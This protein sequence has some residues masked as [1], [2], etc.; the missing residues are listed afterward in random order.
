M[1]EELQFEVVV[2][3]DIQPE[4]ENVVAFGAGFTSPEGTAAIFHDIPTFYEELALGRPLPLALALRDV[5][6]VGKVLAISLFL[7]RDLALH[8]KTLSLVAFADFVDRLGV[9]GLA[10]IDPDVARFFGL[11]TTYLPSDLSPSELRG[12][13]VTV[14][15]WVREYL[16]EDRL[17][18]F[19]SAHPMPRVLDIGTNGFVLAEGVEPLIEG[20]VDLYRQGYL[21]G[22]LF[23]PDCENRRTVLAAR[24]SQFLTFDL[25]KAADILNE[26][27]RAMG[28]VSGWVADELWLWGPRGGTQLPASAVMKVLVRV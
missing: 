22:V 5:A 9:V 18:A 7:H 27:E 28:E 6:A 11:L 8:P 15:G 24:K 14:V 3:P 12:R 10:H 4:V 20:W 17:P 25:R 23:G 21:R 1:V 13:L 19:L 2:N 26:T 16:L